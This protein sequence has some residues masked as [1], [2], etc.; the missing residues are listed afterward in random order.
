LEWTGTFDFL[1]SRGAG[2]GLS[3]GWA[4]VRDNH[5]IPA[6]PRLVGT[7]APSPSAHV[8]PRPHAPSPAAKRR[9]SI[10]PSLVVLILIG[11]AVRVWAI[12]GEDLGLDGGLSLA[13]A[14]LPLSD[15]LQF[16]GRDVHPP[17][18]YV[19]LRPWLSVAGAS[20]F[21]VKY[22]GA[23]FATLGLA[24]LAAWT[25]SVAT[26]RA[27]FVAASAFA[28]APTAIEASAN[29]REYALAITLIVLTAWAYTRWSPPRFVIWGILAIWTSY[30][31]AGVIAAAALDAAR[32]RHRRQRL[33]PIAVVGASIL[34]W[35]AYALSVGFLQTLQSTGPRGTS[36]PEIALLAQLADLPRLLSGGTYL[37]PE[38]LGAA[39]AAL[40]VAV[41]GATLLIPDSLT[42][43]LSQRERELGGSLSQQD[44]E[45][46]RPHPDLTSE[47]Q[48]TG[49]G[50]FLAA[51]VVCSIA[52][53]LVV[54]SN[55]TRQELATRYVLP[56]LPLLLLPFGVAVDRAMRRWPGAAVAAALIVIAGVLGTRSWL[57]RPSLP[58]T[59]WDPDGV[60]QFLDQ[61]TTTADA[62]VFD[63]PEQAGYYQA[64]SSTPR[65]WVLVPVGT[66]YLQGNVVAR[67]QTTLAPL[68]DH[69]N[70][71]W[72]V[73]AHSSL[74][75]GST[76]VVDWLSLHLFAMPPAHL[77]DSDIAPFVGR[78]PPDPA[79]VLN[80]RL[81]GGIELTQ[82]RLP[83]RLAAGGSL[84]IE[85]DWVAHQAVR[86]NLTVFVHLVDSRGKTWAQHDSPPANNRL[87]T[88]AWQIDQVVVDRHGLIVPPSAVPGPYWI[89]VGLYDDQGR[90]PLEA[91]GDTI[92]L[93]P[94]EVTPSP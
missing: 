72:L 91:G 4:T 40:A 8:G 39:L 14:V 94:V 7:Q 53:A 75:E 18:Y 80:V 10:A 52:L 67:S 19:A 32:H 11:F 3:P 24:A 49:L 6:P 43:T 82:A 29:V 33:L 38:W 41:V 65:R 56:V 15:G 37:H 44:R 77:S 81:S 1:N 71:V 69:A 87:P 21:A 57:E 90:L 46:E 85:L 50:F 59:F 51:G 28:V 31:A 22:L 92:R 61:H 48:G 27:A 58:Q 34:P 9:S 2:I 30:L 83:P 17:L 16:L 66:S 12:R 84:P 5:R 76:K 93:G 47:G 89:E 88:T 54:N 23:G 86:R 42:L 64:L 74:G 60:T 35:L 62:I 45:Q 63:S 20:P 79:V 70:V 26:E 36:H 25:R 68:V 73:L 13:L 55:W 78:L